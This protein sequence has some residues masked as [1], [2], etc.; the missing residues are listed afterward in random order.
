MTRGNRG[1]TKHSIAT[2]LKSLDAIIAEEDKAFELSQEEAWKEGAA[3]RAAEQKKR[4][5]M[6]EEELEEEEDQRFRE[7]RQQRSQFSSGLAEKYHSI[8]ERAF[9]A[10]FGKL[11][12]KDWEAL[13]RKWKKF[14]GR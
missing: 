7:R 8:R 10:A 14:A 6:T 5:G 9:E 12:T 13:D 4:E 11:T 1:K 3:E 2:Y